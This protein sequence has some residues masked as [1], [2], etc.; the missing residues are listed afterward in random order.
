M[1]AEGRAGRLS[2][3]E[4]RAPMAAPDPFHSRL[5]TGLAEAVGLALPEDRL[6]AVATALGELLA[7]AAEL[8]KLPL[9]G[10]PAVSAPPRW[11]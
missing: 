6:D 3:A 11:T 2:V 4:P 8:Q 5:V 10:V 7:A 1:V 9:E